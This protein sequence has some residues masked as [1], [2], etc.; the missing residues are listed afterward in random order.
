MQTIKNTLVSWSFSVQ[1]LLSPNCKPQT[2]E[3][4]VQPLDSAATDPTG[5][6]TLQSGFDWCFQHVQTD[7]LNQTAN[8]TAQKSV[9]NASSRHLLEHFLAYLHDGTFAVYTGASWKPCALPVFAAWPA[10]HCGRLEHVQ[11]GVKQQHP[12]LS[13]QNHKIP[14]QQCA[15]LQ[16]VSPR[17]CILVWGIF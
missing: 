15:G 9:P 17:C 14:T 7:S 2:L 4:H 5:P 13:C 16:C 12:T 8:Q 10:A 3:W 1:S 11:P 6:A